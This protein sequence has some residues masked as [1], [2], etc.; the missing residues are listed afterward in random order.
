M[1]V[2]CIYSSVDAGKSAMNRIDASLEWVAPHAVTGIEF[3]SYS[4]LNHG[5]ICW[6]SICTE[7]GPDIVFVIGD[8]EHPLLPGIRD[9]LADLMELDSVSHP[10]IVFTHP[11]GERTDS[12]R[13][14]HNFIKELSQRHQCEF[15]VIGRGDLGDL[16]GGYNECLSAVEFDR[17][18]PW[19]AAA[20]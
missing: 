11:D 2:F 3:F 1:R 15:H 6:A 4:I 20:K 18:D 12:T 16:V 13:D 9:S 17:L 5:V 7:G 19:K 14:A 8:S 10:L